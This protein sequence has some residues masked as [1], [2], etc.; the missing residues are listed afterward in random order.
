MDVA[1]AAALIATAIPGPGGVWADLGAGDGIFSR[2]LLSLLGTSGQVHAVD[3]DPD[4]MRLAKYP[5]IV[6]MRA[7]FRQPL[8]LP[9][10][11]GALFANSLHF[12]A[13][14]RQADVLQAISQHVRAHG[15]IVV[16]EYDNRAASQWVPDPVSFTRL[17]MLA[18][19]AGLGTP[20][21]VG[22]RPSAFG[23]T[24]YAAALDVLL[25]TSGDHAR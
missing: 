25:S 9:A 1:D 7:D 24:I 19:D 14:N 16:A 8:A 2:A 6:P 12:V 13:A 22:S 23:G 21:M 3:R 10:L 4:V 15:V 5:G 17:V 20:R 11:D 18:N